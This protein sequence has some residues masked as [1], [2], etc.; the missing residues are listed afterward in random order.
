MR[1]TVLHS[2][3]WVAFGKAIGQSVRWLTT[4]FTL[5]FLYPEDY[6]VMALS[7]FFLA[8]LWSFSNGGI[9]SALIR[10]KKIDDKLVGE[11][12]T[13]SIIAHSLFFLLLQSIAEPLAQAYNDPRLADVIRVTSCTFLISLIGFVPSTILNRDMQFKKL[14]IVDALSESV[15]ALTTVFLAWKGWGYWSL[16]IGVLVSEFVKQTGYALRNPKWIW[17]SRFTQKIKEIVSFA[18]KSATQAAIGYTVFNV[19]VAIAG[20]FLTTAELGFYQFAVV[21]AMMPAAKVLPMLRQV[22]LPVYSKIQNDLSSLERYFLKTQRISA[23]IFVPIFWGIGAVAS[24]LVP[25]VFGEKWEP[26][27]ILIAVYCI[28][29]PLK[30]LEQLFG[31]LLKAINRVDVTLSNTLIYAIIL[32]PSFFIGAHSGALGLASSW[33]I[34]FLVSFL[35][36]TKRACSAIDISFNNYLREISYPHVVGAAMAGSCLTIGYMFSDMPPILLLVIQVITGAAIYIG[37]LYIFSKQYIF[38]ALDLVRRR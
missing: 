5:R 1:E 16:V 30:C 7:S 24:T 21:L 14:A 23:L 6:A 11:F 32:I 29:M 34:A 19:D 22:A 2:L 8:L 17:P 33:F 10:T 12:F 35:L 31:P 26:A 27:A 20:L 4:I 9:A 15:G 36:A 25:V 13:L 37:L 3:K 18:W 38:E 28:T